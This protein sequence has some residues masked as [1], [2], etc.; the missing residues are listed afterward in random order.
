MDRQRDRVRSSRLGLL[1]AGFTLFLSTTLFLGWR[2]WKQA[3]TGDVV[4]SIPSDTPSSHQTQ[5]IHSGRDTI[6]SP[7]VADVDNAGH[8][9]LS[10]ER[11]V[12][13]HALDEVLEL[14]R[15]ALARHREKHHDYTA[16]LIKT[17]RIGK[18]LA[19]TTKMSMKLRYRE[20]IPERNLRGVD[21]YFRFL[22]PK[23][24]AG[25]EVIY[26][27][28]KYN[29]ML[30]A[31]ESGLLG[32]LT[33]EL[34]PNSQLAMR[35]NRYPIT[36][37]GIEKLI[38]KLVEKGE[39]DRLRGE[40][41][42]RRSV[43]QQ[44]EGRPCELIEVIH[45]ERRFMQ[46]GR[47][48]DHEFYKAKIWFDQDELVPIKYASYLWPREEGGDPLL[49]EEYTYSELQFNVGL[50]DLDFDIENPDYRFP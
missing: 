49:E 46:N 2:W 6:V 26:A 22:E 1:L 47:A 8:Q 40:C 30:K 9:T 36:E 50:S 48:E 19:P 11:P 43:D 16:N 44:V 3:T 17:E 38:I 14:A 23:A 28:N 21:V 35:G 20:L 33:V 45:P 25:R 29:G 27:P 32:L 31:H 39:R 10:N 34:S 41:E 5:I 12:E 37:V 13:N 15:T 18:N 7:I 42:V 24:Q 4:T